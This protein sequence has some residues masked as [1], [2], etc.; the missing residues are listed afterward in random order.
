M[1]VSKRSSRCS[2]SSYLINSSAMSRLTSKT[3]FWMLSKEFCKSISP[4]HRVQ[5]GCGQG[6]SGGEE[7]VKVEVELRKKCGGRRKN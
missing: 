3:K 4:S 1:S 7:E 5:E 6:E 2:R